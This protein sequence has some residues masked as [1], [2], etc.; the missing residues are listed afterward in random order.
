MVPTIKIGLLGF[1]TVGSGV[2]HML[3][4]NKTKIAQKKHVC[5][6]VSKILVGNIS[7]YQSEIEKGLPIT[8]EF[9]EILAD[10]SIE[11]V[12]EVMG[13][14]ETAREYIIQSLEAGKNVVTA[15]K[16]ALALYG[17]ELTRIAKENGK[18]LLFEASVAGGIPIIRTLTDSYIADNIQEISGIINGTTNF[19]ISRMN[20]EKESYQEALAL[21]QERG[22]AEADPTGDVEGLDAA[23]KLIILVKLAFGY[24]LAM[25]DFPIEGITHATLEDFAAAEALG[26][27]LKL[28]GTAKRMNNDFQARVGMHL[29]P[30]SHPLAMVKNEYNGVFVKGEAIGETMLYGPG[31]G[32]LPTANS[33]VSDILTVSDHISGHQ[34][35]KFM[36][37]ISENHEWHKPETLFLDALLRV[38]N[39]E[40][41]LAALQSAHLSFKPH[42]KHYLMLFGISESQLTDLQDLDEIEAIF[43]KL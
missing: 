15:N 39:N 23:R 22:F 24:R 7:K 33:V 26:Y 31:A 1:G 4:E 19:I 37:L 35:G 14:A 6:E 40:S 12:V 5:F 42:G 3:T 29:I 18:D 36:P 16:D 38:K 11:I 25:S 32:S 2:Y 20:D 17:D 13:S 28:I 41:L 30:T 43:R 8:T 34:T 10:N 9:S 27:T 21:A